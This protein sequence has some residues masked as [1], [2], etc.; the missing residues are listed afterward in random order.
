MRNNHLQA[1]FIYLEKEYNYS[2][3]T[4]ECPVGSAPDGVHPDLLDRPL[5]E[6]EDSHVPHYYFGWESWP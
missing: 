5:I 3:L 1:P 4:D 6:M 2:Q